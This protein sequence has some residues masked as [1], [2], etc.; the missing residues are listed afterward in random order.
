MSVQVKLTS[1]KTLTNAST[2]AIVELSNFN[3]SAIT[4]SIKE[5]L[6]TINYVQGD[7]RVSVDIHT[8]ASNLLTVRNGLSVY[9]TQ[10]GS[11]TAPPVISLSS[12][13]ELR[14]KSVVAEDAAEVLRIRMNVFGALP[15]VGTP[16]EI[17]YIVAQGEKREG[18]YVWLNSTGWTL[19]SGGGGGG[20]ASCMQEVVFTV[21]ADNVTTDNTEASSRLYLTPA[22]MASTSF[23]LFVNGQLMLV[24]D[25]TTNAPAYISEDNG[26]TAVRYNE[27]N[28]NCKIFWNPTIAGY[29]L[30]DDDLLTVHYFSIDPFCSQSGFACNTK[31][32]LSG[33]TNTEY[34][35]GVEIISAA[36]ADGPFSVCKIPNPAN[37][38]GGED[39]PVGYYLSNAIDSFS[40]TDWEDIFPSGAILKF[41]LPSSI[42]ESEFDQVSIFN[43]VGTQFTD[44]TI[45]ASQSSSPYVPVYATRSIYAQLQTGSFGAVYLIQ[46]TEPTSTTTTST[47]TTTTAAPGSTTTSTTT[48]APN[49]ISFSTTGGYYPTTVTFYGSPAGPFD[50][51]FNKNGTNYSLTGLLGYQVTLPWTFNVNLPTFSA[52]QNAVGT[53][54]FTRTNGCVYTISVP[55]GLT[56]TSTTVAPGTTT[57]STST[58]STTTAAPGTTTTSTSTTTTTTLAPRTPRGS[59]TTTSSTT[60]TTLP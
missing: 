6:R 12:T 48:C 52:I 22:P 3:F 21:E 56:T 24:G 30:E 7:S 17:I 11:G 31:V 28:A 37:N 41:T 59:T 47:T 57:T 20:T 13:G 33:A 35:Y 8:I 1:V 26:S 60:T 15:P 2:T 51:V 10:L 50:I 32:I 45:Y 16:G 58:T 9:G 29:T 40:F 46:G 43:Q 25:G 39:L 34:A 49:Q 36:T 23:M 38:L 19:L 44:V 4:S 42:S 55:T 27:A 54:T 18:V 14:A 53:Y 5:F